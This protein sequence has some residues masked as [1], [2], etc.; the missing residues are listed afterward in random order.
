VTP[1]N[2]FQHSVTVQCRYLQ[3]LPGLGFFLSLRYQAWFFGISEKPC[4]GRLLEPIQ[5]FLG[6]KEF[7]VCGVE[8]SAPNRFESR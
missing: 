7:G 8:I 5:V 1:V 6:L 4:L 3:V 2:R